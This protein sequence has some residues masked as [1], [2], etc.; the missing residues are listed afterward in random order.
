MRDD[1]SLLGTR[2]G[3]INDDEPAT[4]LEDTRGGEQIAR[5]RLFEKVDIGVRGHRQSDGSDVGENGDE[6]RDIG[7]RELRGP[8]DRAAGTQVAMVGPKPHRNDAGIDRL[9]KIDFAAHMHFGKIAFEKPL[10]LRNRHHRPIGHVYPR[11]FTYSCKDPRRMVQLGQSAMVDG[12]TA[13]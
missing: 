4:E 12:K 10:D 2:D 9:N 8:G 11:S 1:C 5:R 13:A 7:E 6:G 3:A